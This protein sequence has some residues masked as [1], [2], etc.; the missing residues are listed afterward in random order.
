MATHSIVLDR[1][2]IPEGSPLP[3]SSTGFDRV[4]AHQKRNI[5]ALGASAALFVTFLAAVASML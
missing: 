4:L 3:A 5:A 1:V 2:S